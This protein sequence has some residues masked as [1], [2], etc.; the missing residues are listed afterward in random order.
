MNVIDSGTWPQYFDDGAN[1]S[2]IAGPIGDIEALVVPKIS[3]CEVLKR[4]LQQR[5]ESAAL[6]A[7]AAMH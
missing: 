3:R 5:D 1:A 2:F 4:A 6:Q 7:M